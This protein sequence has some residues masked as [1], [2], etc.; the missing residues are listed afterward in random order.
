MECEGTGGRWD[1]ETCSCQPLWEDP[2]VLRLDG[3]PVQLTDAAG[4][5][6]FDLDGTGLPRPIAWTQTGSTAA[7][8]VLD[9][10][11]DGAITTG[12]E[13]FG[14][15]VGTRRRHRRAAGENSFTLLAAYDTVALG[16]NGDGR[17]RRLGAA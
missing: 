10:N 17:I 3:K 12:A 14:V 5:V 1:L 8:L 15:P 4:G 7:F 13:L 2:L 9:Q 16:W 6:S 11:Q